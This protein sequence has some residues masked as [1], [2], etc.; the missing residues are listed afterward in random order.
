M[1]HLSFGCRFVASK[2]I[3]YPVS[4]TAAFYYHSN[5]A[6]DKAYETLVLTAIAFY[7]KDPAQMQAALKKFD[8]QYSFKG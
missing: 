8:F 1:S 2:N 7:V 4:A 3:I 5:Q 6:W